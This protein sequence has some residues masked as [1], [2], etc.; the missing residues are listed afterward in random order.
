MGLERR[1]LALAELVHKRVFRAR[2]ARPAW[3]AAG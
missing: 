1:K 2:V 3:A